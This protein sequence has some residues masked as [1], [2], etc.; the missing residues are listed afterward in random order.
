MAPLASMQDSATTL[1]RT[2]ALFADPTRF[3][4]NDISSPSKN[5]QEQT[6]NF[7]VYLARLH[8]THAR[9]QHG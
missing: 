7:I 4:V 1:V 8:R 2:V 5:N 6:C 3:I 9:F